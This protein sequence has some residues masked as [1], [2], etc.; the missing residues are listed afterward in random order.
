MNCYKVK[1]RLGR[2]VDGE[3]SLPV[4]LVIEQHLGRCP[5]CLEE[6]AELSKIG[7]LLQDVKPPPTPSTLT[8]RILTRACATPSRGAFGARIDGWKSWFRQMRF[9]AA[10]T[11]FLA[12]CLGLLLSG[13][14]SA[15]NNA[16]VASFLPS[17]SGGPLVVAYQ[18]VA[19]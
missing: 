1:R 5:A 19:Q 9:A 14:G 4:T 6:L 17:A 8:L 3:L 18:G 10:G 16:D 7:S 2:Y 11:T 15:R 13:G 12:I